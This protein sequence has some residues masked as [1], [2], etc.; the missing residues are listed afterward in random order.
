MGLSFHR[1]T[2]DFNA[3]AHCAGKINAL[4][5]CAFSGSRLE[6]DQGVDKLTGV[7]GHLLGSEANFAD[8]RV[9]DTVLVN[10]KVDFTFLHFFMNA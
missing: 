7:V 2:V 1:F 8:R 5:I 6:F 4:D 3:G 10:L 9:N